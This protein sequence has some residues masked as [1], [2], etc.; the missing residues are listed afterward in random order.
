MPRQKLWFTGGAI[1]VVL[2]IAASLTLDIAS[3][4]QP[5][6]PSD[7]FWSFIPLLTQEDPPATP[8]PSPTATPR[9]TTIAPTSTRPPLGSIVVDHTSVALFEQIPE[10]YLNAAANLRMLFIDRSVGQNIS[11]GLTCLGYPSDEEAP[12]HCKRYIHPVSIYSVNPGEVNWSRPGGYSRSNW[13]YMP[14]EGDC[15]SWSKKLDCFFALAGP[16]INQYDVVSFQFSYLE[17]GD[18]NDNIDDQPGG[19]FWDNP[20]YSDVY[21]QEAFEAQHP[22]QVFIYWTSS[23]ARGIGTNTALR[24]NDQMRQY[25]VAN[26]KPLFDVADILS[27]TPD[28]RPCYDNRDGV[29]Y[30]TENYPNDG[31]NLPAICQEYTTETDGGHLGSVS[32]GKIRVAKAFWVLMARIAGWDGVSR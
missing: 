19:Y 5:N 22:G 12:S 7:D 17:V 3:G 23:L 14:W 26:N 28:G 2:F 25:A 9:P 31:Q 1:L 18:E 4:R 29:P 27:H 15:S 32:A 16:V 20:S 11:D 6:A 21:D 24:F 8:A 10:Q 30:L 13:L